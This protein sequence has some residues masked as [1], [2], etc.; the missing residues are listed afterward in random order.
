MS[1]HKTVWH[2]RERGSVY[3]LTGSEGQVL[4]EVRVN[5]LDW[6]ASYNGKKFIT[7]EDAQ[8]AAEAFCGVN[9]NLKRA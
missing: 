8:R 7:L 1:K 5:S 6:T 3:F 9:I 2:A 4:A